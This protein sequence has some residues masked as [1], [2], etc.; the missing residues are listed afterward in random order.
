[1]TGHELKKN[2]EFI[3]VFQRCRETLMD[4]LV[5]RMEDNFRKTEE[6]CI[7]CLPLNH[8]L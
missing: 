5:G 1:M 8:E 2:V 4:F 7:T 3:K 6:T